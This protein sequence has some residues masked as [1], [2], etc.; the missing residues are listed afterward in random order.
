MRRGAS[1]FAA[2]T[3]SE[4]ATI[5]AQLATGTQVILEKAE[6]ALG[7]RETEEAHLPDMMESIN[8]TE[9]EATLA[10]KKSR[11]AD[12]P[13]NINQG[14]AAAYTSLA[15]NLTSA[16]QT[17]LA[18]P[19][20]VIEE[21]GNHQVSFGYLMACGGWTDAGLDSSRRLAKSYGQS[22]SRSCKA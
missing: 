15:S 22:R 12:Q 19:M 3:L 11:Y 8:L 9:Y 7:G 13:A 18:V 4:V 17:I 1:S 10:G 20:E 6:R 5:G 2:N 14:I 21:A 16:A